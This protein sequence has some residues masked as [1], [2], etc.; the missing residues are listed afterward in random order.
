M[1]NFERFMDSLNLRYF[2]P[3]EFLIGLDRGNDPPPE[4]LW[5][6]IALPATLLDRLRA[7]LRLPVKITSTYR[8]PWYN[9]SVGGTL[10]SQHQAF[11]AI[12][13][14][15]VGLGNQSEAAALLKGWR[16]E[17]VR[18][19]ERFERIPVVVGDLEIPFRELETWQLVGG[20]E[21]LT[22]FAGGVGTYQSF[23]HLDGRGVNATWEGS[24]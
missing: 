23:T 11:A 10:R 19:S 9:S 2:T 15:V 22:R 8:S 5:P 13:F 1:T 6:N 14:E 17:L 7:S 21:T 4:Y 16:G 18:M 12:D 20:S 3:G 24:A